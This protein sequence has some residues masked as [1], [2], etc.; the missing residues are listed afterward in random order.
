[1][2]IRR[3]FG[4]DWEKVGS[5]LRQNGSWQGHIEHPFGRSP[6]CYR[7]CI[8][9]YCI[10]LSRKSEYASIIL[11]SLEAMELVGRDSSLL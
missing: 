4:E 5:R 1:M 9:E 2:E 6:V 11:F 3:S 10:Y 7:W 8:D